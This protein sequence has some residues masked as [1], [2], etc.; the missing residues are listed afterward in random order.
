M[1][2]ED[3]PLYT[4]QEI[5]KFLEDHHDFVSHKDVKQ[6]F[7]IQ[8]GRYFFEMIKNKDSY[9]WDK[10]VKQPMFEIG[11]PKF[12]LCIFA[13]YRVEKNDNKEG[14]RLTGFLE[15]IE[16]PFENTIEGDNITLR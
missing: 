10:E 7:F 14:Q 4:S 9:S 8:I 15:K 3:E 11:T 1:T 2:L 16:A 13:Y 5:D 6:D 12:K